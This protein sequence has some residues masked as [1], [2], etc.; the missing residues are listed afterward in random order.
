MSL[1][2]I[3]TIDVTSMTYTFKD[4]IHLRCLMVYPNPQRPILINEAWASVSICTGLRVTQAW[5][6]KINSGEAAAAIK[7]IYHLCQ[8]KCQMRNLQMKTLQCC[9][10]A[11]C[12]ISCSWRRFKA[13]RVP[14]TWLRI[15]KWEDSVLFHK[16]WKLFFTDFKKV[17]VMAA[18]IIYCIVLFRFSCTVTGFHPHLNM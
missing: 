12:L 1:E 13:Q 2:C 6:W 10:I 5:V 4:I 14:N 3:W 16:R 9:F 17:K 11:W 8:T 15:K 18:N 7:W